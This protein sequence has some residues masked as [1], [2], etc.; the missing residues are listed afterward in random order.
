VGGVNVSG[1]VNG[2]IELHDGIVADGAVVHGLRDDAYNE[3]RIMS[4]CG[5]RC[6]VCGVSCMV[7]GVWCMVYGV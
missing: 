6:M 3:K 7:Y 4:V 2:K 5:V 1:P